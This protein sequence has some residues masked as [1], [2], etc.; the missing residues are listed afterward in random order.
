MQKGSIVVCINDNFTID[1]ISMFNK[2][3]VKGEE[4]MVREMVIIGTS[5]RPGVRLEEIYGKVIF[6]RW[7]GASGYTEFHFKQDRFTE[8][9]PPI[10]IEIDEFKDI[11]EEIEIR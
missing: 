5:K 11:G 3:P 8:V 2:M 1:N 9:L 6:F 4:Y 10:E 7:N